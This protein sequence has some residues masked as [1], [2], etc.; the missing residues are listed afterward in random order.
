MFIDFRERGRERETDRHGCGG[1][2]TASCAHPDWGSNPK[3]R[4]VPWPRIKHGTF[5]LVYGTTFQPTEPPGQGSSIWFFLKVLFIYLFRERGREGER[6]GEKHRCVVAS[7]WSGNINHA[8]PT[9]DLA[10]NPGMCPDWES[11]QRPFGLQAGIQSTELRQ[12]GP[13]LFYCFSSSDQSYNW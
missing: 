5:F 10:C 1:W 7:H 8:A 9:G 13:V 3:P 12:P 4:Y 6:E 11:N 2:S